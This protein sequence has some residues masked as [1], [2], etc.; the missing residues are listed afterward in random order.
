M[1]APIVEKNPDKIYL[2]S[3]AQQRT[4]DGFMRQLE[5]SLQR[6][7]VDKID[8]YHIHNLRPQNDPNL[9]I[10]EKGAYKA[11]LKAKEQG[12]I[13]AFGVTGHSGAQILIDAVKRFD[14]N[15][16]LTIFPANRPDNG[17]Y[18]DE[19]L[20][21]ARERNMGI[22]GMKTVKQAHNSDLK[23]SDLIRYALSLDG[24]ASTIVGLDTLGY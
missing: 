17:R 14:P 19:L 23:G 18:E 8:L 12:L 15:A 16:L 13:G 4:Y 10:T 24:V 6:L 22:V 3:K 2:V 11:A 1:I 9:D 20:P 5:E 21:L 7:R